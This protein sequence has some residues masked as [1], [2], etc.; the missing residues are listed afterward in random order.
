[1]RHEVGALLAHDPPTQT[2]VV[3]A[4]LRPK[5]ATTSFAVFLLTIFPPRYYGLLDSYMAGREGKSA[6]TSSNKSAYPSFA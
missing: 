3:L 2:T 5:L 1:M 6:V 4:S